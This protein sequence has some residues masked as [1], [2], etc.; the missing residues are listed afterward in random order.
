MH[1]TAGY[2]YATQYY[3]DFV[4]LCFVFLCLLVSVAAHIFVSARQ[5]AAMHIYLSLCFLSLSLS[6]AFAFAFKDFDGNPT[7]LGVQEDAAAFLSRLIDK[8][9]EEL[10]A[11]PAGR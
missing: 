11:V 5:R 9:N 1:L 7:D 6:A 4:F 3:I 10:A 8:L 2:V